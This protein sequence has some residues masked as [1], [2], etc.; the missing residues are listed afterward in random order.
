MIDDPAPIGGRVGRIVQGHW[1]TRQTP[2]ATQRRSLETAQL[3]FGDVRQEL[4]TIIDTD[5]A[6]LEA[7]LEAAGAP[8]T[9][10]RR[11]STVKRDGP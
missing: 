11:L 7:D 8:W 1:N 3:E 9:P 5:V 10:G 6:Q 4:S 2:T